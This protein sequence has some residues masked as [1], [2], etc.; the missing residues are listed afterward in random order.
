MDLDI[1]DSPRYKTHVEDSA[2]D[3]YLSEVKNRKA[4][5][6]NPK[7]EELEVN[8]D[9]V[10]E[11]SFEECLNKAL[12][13]VYENVNSFK[14]TECKFKKDT[15]QLILEGIVKFNSGKQRTGRYTFN[16]CIVKENNKIKLIGKSNLFEGINKC[17]LLG[18]LDTANCLT[19]NIISYKG[20]IGKDL[21]EG[22]ASASKEKLN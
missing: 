16:K 9:D 22:Y 7:F 5:K 15:N 2:I 4:G 20:H 3:A 10:D 13:D 8:I 21:I 12:K 1:L 11:E 14:L 18:T 6:S 19:T 17:V